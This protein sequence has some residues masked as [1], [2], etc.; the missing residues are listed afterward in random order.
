MRITIF[1]QTSTYGHRQLR[2]RDPVRSPIFK[3][4][5]A[6]LVLRILTSV[7]GVHLLSL[8]LKVVG[9][10]D[11]ALIAFLTDDVHRFKF[12]PHDAES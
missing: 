2:T 7:S 5:T 9:M 4:L 12:Y 1:H 11:K 8:V 10:N 6:R 3:Q